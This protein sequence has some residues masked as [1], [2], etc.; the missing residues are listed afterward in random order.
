MPNQY[1]APL[2]R[3]NFESKPSEAERLSPESAIYEEISDE[4]PSYP[5]PNRPPPPLPRPEGFQ[6]TVSRPPSSFPPPLPQRQAPLPPP[7][8]PP[9][10]LPPNNPPPIPA[11]T[12]GGPPIPARNPH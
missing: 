8:H 2:T 10:S 1:P 5:I 9:P 3:N 7:Q 11:R 4:A 6:E 12:T